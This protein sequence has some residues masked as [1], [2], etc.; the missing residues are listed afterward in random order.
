MVENKGK[1]K[2]QRNTSGRKGMNRGKENKTKDWSNCGKERRET[3]FLQ[4][5]QSS[6]SVTCE[7]GA[8]GRSTQHLSLLW[9]VLTSALFS[10]PYSDYELWI[11]SE[12][13][14]G[15]AYWNMLIF[16]ESHATGNG[17]NTVSQGNHRQGHRLKIK[18]EFVKS[19][20]FGKISSVFKFFMTERSLMVCLWRLLSQMSHLVIKIR[21]LS[22]TDLSVAWSKA[23]AG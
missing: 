13:D 6:S 16:F 14:V 8:L 5:W 11:C 7:T 4:D 23:R 12:V 19:S 10:H 1:N 3:F 17:S 21:W 18:I 20:Y 9:S 2:R 22:T 15:H